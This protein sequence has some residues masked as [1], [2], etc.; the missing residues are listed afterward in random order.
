MSADRAGTRPQS[1]GVTQLLRA[2][3]HRLEAAGIVHARAEAEWLLSHLM[4]CAPLELYLEERPV[5]ERLAEEF[6]A[7]LTR[8]AAGTPLQYVLGETEWCGA[9]IRVAPGVFI[10]RP[11]TEAV[12]DAARE[13]L[14]RRAAQ[15]SRPMR[16]LDLGTGSGCM[17]IALAQA[18][19][20]CVVVGI[21]L[22]WE[23]LCVA[24]SNIRRHGLAA[25]VPLVQG[26]W[27][28]AVT[29][30]FD[31]VVSNPPYVPSAH[32]ERLPLDVRQEPRRSLDGG[33]DGLCHLWQVIE[34]APR[35]LAPEGI[36]A[37]E[38]GEEQAGILSQA[39][40]ARAWV[41]AVA[42]IADLAGR[43]RGLLIYSR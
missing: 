13:A 23:A 30:P 12:V 4:G 2:G 21:E 7:R 36:L 20:A 41:K 16:L 9:R 27:A 39:V 18:L 38:C 32:V 8:R 17:A 43:P 33:P 29:G 15:V 35:V 26:D 6:F 3:I 14:R 42:G 10:P 19:P 24:R 25:R 34:Q 22:S 40:A 28:T 11:E 1:S 5:P 37:L 31:G